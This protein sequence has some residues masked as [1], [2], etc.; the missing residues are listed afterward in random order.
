MKTYTIFLLILLVSFF[1][2]GAVLAQSAIWSLNEPTF[3]ATT[4]SVGG[5]T[6]IAPTALMS[7]YKGNYEEAKQQAVKSGKS[8]VVEVYS[9]G[10]GSASHRME[11]E[12]YNNPIVQ[13]L[14]SQKFVVVRINIDATLDDANQN[15]LA[16][17]PVNFVPSYFYFNTEG[18][19]AGMANG[20]QNTDKFL[21][22]AKKYA[23]NDD[24]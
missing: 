13:T 9:T 2:N 5:A 20:F 3:T 7:F 16:E 18:A 24:K 1:C 14:Y 11:T 15:F 4:E 22:L 6:D 10:N 8:L 17:H 23:S 21:Q 12:V 19:Y